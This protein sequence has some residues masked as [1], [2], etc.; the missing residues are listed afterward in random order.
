MNQRRPKGKKIQI[1]RRQVFGV[2]T[3]NGCT[4]RSRDQ[5]M[6]IVNSMKEVD[7]K[8]LALQETR[9]TIGS[10]MWKA[11]RCVVFEHQP[12]KVLKVNLGVRQSFV[13][14]CLKRYPKSQRT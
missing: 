10:K 4:V 3:H 5:R 9:R 11:A 8:V 12:K 13:E 1:D 6:A 14:T 2:A 7:V